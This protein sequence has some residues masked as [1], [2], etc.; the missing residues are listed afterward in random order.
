MT[1]RLSLPQLPTVSLGSRFQAECAGVLILALY[2]RVGWSP[3][4]QEALET[5]PPSQCCLR[6]HP[7]MYNEWLAERCPFALSSCG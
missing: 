6:S 4:L 2:R 3:P 1:G 7:R 5:I